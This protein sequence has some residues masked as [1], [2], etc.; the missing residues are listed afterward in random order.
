MRLLLTSLLCL[1]KTIAGI[2]LDMLRKGFEPRTKIGDPY[3]AMNKLHFKRILLA[4]S[5]LANQRLFCFVR[6]MG[7]NLSSTH[8]KA[9]CG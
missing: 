2:I 8:A 3:A 9:C 6:E 1:A 7:N 5:S 4:L